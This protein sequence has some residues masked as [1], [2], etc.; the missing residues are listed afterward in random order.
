MRRCHPDEAIQKKKSLS[1]LPLMYRTRTQAFCHVRSPQYRFAVMSC[2]SFDWC[3]NVLVSMSLQF[4][5]CRTFQVLPRY[6]RCVFVSLIPNHLGVMHKKKGERH[7]KMRGREKMP[8]PMRLKK[9]K[10]SFLQYGPICS[11]TKTS[12]ASANRLVV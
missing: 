9:K 11:A 7:Q 4:L 10:H 5:H 3:V 6:R 2:P 1:T 8:P 12:T